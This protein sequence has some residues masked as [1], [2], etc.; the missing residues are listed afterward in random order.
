MATPALLRRLEDL[1]ARIGASA[2]VAV[3]WHC[4]T[5]GAAVALG[6]AGPC[7]DHRPLPLAETVLMVV[8]VAPRP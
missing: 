8:F 5:C 1:E 6:D 4:P 3:G 7:S 2:Q